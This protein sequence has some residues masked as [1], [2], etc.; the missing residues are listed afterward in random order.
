MIDDRTQKE[1]VED[2]RLFAEEEVRPHAG[3][4]DR[5]EKISS[6]L[7]QKMADRK[8]LVASIPVELGGL[9]LDPVHYGRMT[10][11]IG[12]ACSNA[13]S[14]I[15]VQDSLIGE[16]LARWGTANQKK[17]WL[18]PL[19]AGKH[20]GAF[21]LSE[22]EHGSDARGIETAY[23]K[24][25]G[26]YRI[27]GKKMWISFGEIADFYIV[28]A[29]R[30][31]KMSAFIVDRKSPGVSVRPMKGLLGNR[32]SHLAEITFKDVPVTDEDLLGSE[33]SG[34][35]FI[36]STALDHGRYSIAWAGVATAQECLELMAEYA[37]SRKQFGQAIGTYQLV[38]RMISDAAAGTR[39]TRAL[40]EY[41][42]ELRKQNSPDAVPETAV[43][44]YFSSRIAMQAAAD[45]VQVHGGN[46]CSNRFP[47][48][49]LF[50]EAKIL[51]IIEGTSQIQ[52]QLIA[53]YAMKKYG[54]KS[55]DRRRS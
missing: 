9:G 33:G 18:A 53:K 45:A 17:C 25:V 7:I 46:G 41:A 31:G 3:R 42:G 4:F 19:A 36:A 28:F 52:Q 35:T 8:Y 51:E 20:I 39:A 15:T 5:E 40:C 26:G 12:R 10:E 30:S 23:E 50:R 43:A 29:N 24:S 54:R 47:V 27:N 14:L 2:A 13:R 48:E 21:A 55:L 16:T 37:R 38:Q 34:F 49:R 22:P 6:E 11:E 32:A 44:K 1:I